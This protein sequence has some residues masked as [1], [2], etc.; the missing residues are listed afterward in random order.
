MIKQLTRIS[1][2]HEKNSNVKIA[3]FRQLYCSAAYYIY[4]RYLVIP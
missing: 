1:K 4:Y 3:Y 2:F